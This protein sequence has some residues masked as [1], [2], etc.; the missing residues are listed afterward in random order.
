MRRRRSS[1]PEACGATCA[2]CPDRRTQSCSSAGSKPGC[3]ERD[4][5]A[6][7]VRGLALRI[8]PDDVM[9]RRV[10]GRGRDREAFVDRLFAIVDHLAQPGLDDREYAVAHRAADGGAF[11]GPRSIAEKWS[12]WSC[13][14]CTWRSETSAP[15]GR[16]RARVPADV[17]VADGC[18][19]PCRCPRVYAGRGEALEVGRIELIPERAMLARFVIADAG[20]DQDFFAADL[21]Q[22]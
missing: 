18:T 17:I 2:R 20:V 11:N 7:E 10:A 1:S 3:R 21:K 14:R 5:V 6:A 4:Y 8:E 22:P 19:S 16:F 12:S 15:S 9:A 13:S